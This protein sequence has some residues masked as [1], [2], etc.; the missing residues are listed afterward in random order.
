[1]NK[2]DRIEL[3]HMRD[4]AREAIS[5][6]EGRTAEDLRRDRIFLLALVKEIEIIGAA[7]S[8]VSEESK[9]LLPGFAWADMTGMRNRLIRA[10]AEI[11]R[12]AV[13]EMTKSF[14]EI[15]RELDILLT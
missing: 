9:R 5:F 4:A 15:T 7:A 8:R 3:L 1:M 13:W 12:S 10:Y 6:A 11:D 2:R 14:P